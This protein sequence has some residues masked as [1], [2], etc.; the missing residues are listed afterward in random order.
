MN[1]NRIE[2]RVKP[3]L[4]D[5]RDVSLSEDLK[6]GIRELFLLRNPGAQT[7]A[8]TVIKASFEELSEEARGAAARFLLKVCRVVPEW[9]TTSEVWEAFSSL[10]QDVMF[11]EDL[12][13]DVPRE[14]DYFKI[15]REVFETQVSKQQDT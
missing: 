7:F 2:Y 4:G 14:G 1:A 9:L 15:I 3:D 8:T 12:R 11:R 10:E 6:K 13:I 5:G